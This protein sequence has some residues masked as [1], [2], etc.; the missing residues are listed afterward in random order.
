MLYGPLLYGCTS[1][2]YEGKPVGT[3][4]AANFWRVIERHRVSAL[5]SAPTAIRAIR[6][7]DENAQKVKEFDTSSL[8][9]IFVAGERAD[10][11]TLK[12]AEDAFDGK[13]PVRDHWWQTET[14]WP[15]CGNIIGIDGPLPV[16]YGSSYTPLPG[17]DVNILDDEN[18]VLPAN[19]IG[20]IAV[21]LPL[22]PGTLLTL[23][24]ADD[25]FH[26]SYLEKI[27][28][29]Y[30][31]GD[32]GMK[33]A[34]GNVYIMSRTDD[35]MNVAG[36]R[37]SSGAMEEVLSDLP[38]VA[39][40]AVIGVRDTFKGHLPLGLLVLNSKCTRS[41]KDILADAIA[42]VRE[43]IGAVASFKQAVI[44]NKLPKTRSGKILR[45]TMRSIANGEKYKLPATIED[46]SVLEE[47]EKIIRSK[48]DVE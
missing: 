5:F 42:I 10:T 19:T 25:R 31:T 24:N 28:G 2:L 11:A 36:H 18:R 26:K 20:N 8:R 47:V 32:A 27:P 23:Y 30:D 38:D 3:P 13:V 48:E 22:P 45:A 44:V 4:D 17:Y 39:E 41:H 37:L 43:R 7:E 14:G 16:Q 40:V 12:W 1:L 9:T 33:D 46:V 15:I 21:K 6:R 29:Y 34:E 35:V